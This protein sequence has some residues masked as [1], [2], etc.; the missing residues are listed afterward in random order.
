MKPEVRRGVAYIAGR[1]VR[2]RRGSALYDYSSSGYSH[3]SGTVGKS[4]SV[5]DH[6][7]RAHIAGSASSLF[8]YGVRAHITLH[9]KGNAFTGYDYD[10]R[11][12]FS[13]QVRQSNIS[14]YDYGEAKHFQFLLA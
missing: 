3:F 1:L 8:H 6:S 12:A 5:Y 10:S 2:D 9:V 14:I 11:S 4:V 7:A 13:G